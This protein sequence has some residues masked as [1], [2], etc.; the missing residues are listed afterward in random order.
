MGATHRIKVLESDLTN[1]TNA[2]AQAITLLAIPAGAIVRNVYAL[3]HQKF[4]NTADAAFN[5]TALT[6]GDGTT[7]NK[8]VASAELNANGTVVRTIAGTGTQ[9]GFDAAGSLVATFASMTGKNLAA[10]NQGELWVFVE[11]IA[12]AT[13]DGGNI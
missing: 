8:F 2:A 6:I 3:N 4:A 13:Y 11:L 9:A 5:T 12:T 7:A 10:L 1:T